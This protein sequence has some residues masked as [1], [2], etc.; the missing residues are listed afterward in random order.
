MIDGSFFIYFHEDIGAVV[1]EPD[2][3]EFDLQANDDLS[4]IL[5]IETQIDET[6]TINTQTDQIL[7]IHQSSFFDL[8]R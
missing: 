7:E 5:N 1:W 3:L 8:N 2:T 6:L 4:F